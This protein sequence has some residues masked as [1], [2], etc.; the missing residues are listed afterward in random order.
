MSDNQ[1]AAMMVADDAYAGSE[2]FYKLADA[3]QDVLG[4]EYTMPVHQGR[5][6]EHLLAKVF[7]K[8][9][10][11]VP[12]ELPLHHQQ[13]ARRAGRRH[14]AGDLRRRSP[15]HRQRRTRSKATWTSRSS[16]TPSQKYGAEQDRLRA[17][18]SHHQPDRR[19]AVLAAEPARGESG[20]GGARHP[21]GLRR[22]PDLRERLL[23]QAARAGLRRQVDPGHH[24]RDDEPGGHRVPVRAQEH[25]RARRPD[26]HQRQEV[27]RP[28]PGLA[29]GVRGLRHLRRHVHQGSRGHGRRPAR[30]DRRSGR[31]R[32]GR[33]HQATSST[34]WSKRACRQ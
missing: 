29:A 25:G 30:D 14:R 8:P 26:R 4:F 20:R 13:G 12:D 6:A 9:G 2:S 24:P 17:H 31:R 28:A 21:A 34:G 11:V 19:P 10:D 7:V 15:E 16:R 22:Q 5:A 3:V 32:I 18:G 33:L 1:L 23:H 27:L